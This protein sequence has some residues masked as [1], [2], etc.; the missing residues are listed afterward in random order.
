M[1]TQSPVLKI[2]PNKKPGK[3]LVYEGMYECMVNEI[4]FTAKINVSINALWA[5]SVV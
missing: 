4:E 3:K 2:K 5:T 1:S